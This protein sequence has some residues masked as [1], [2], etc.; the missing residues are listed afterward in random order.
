[1]KCTG[2]DNL[3]VIAT[4]DGDINHIQSYLIEK[5]HFHHSTIKVFQIDEFPLNTSGKVQYAEIL[6]RFHKH[7]T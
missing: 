1:V 2:E 3:L 6:R 7:I 5:Y 4:L